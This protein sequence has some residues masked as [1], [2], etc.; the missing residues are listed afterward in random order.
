MQT[1]IVI[2]RGVTMG[3]VEHALE[4]RL[5]A[6]ATEAMLGGGYPHLY[7]AGVRYQRETP[8]SE[9]W[10]TPD[11]TIERGAGDCEDLAAYRC[12]ELRATG[13]DPEAVVRVVPAGRSTLHALI[14]RTTGPEEWEDPSVVLGMRPAGR[15][16]GGIY[17]PQLVAGLGAEDA[18]AATC[19]RVPSREVVVAPT[20]RQAVAELGATGIPVLDTI[21][22]AASGALRAVLPDGTV[23]RATAEQV[24][25]QTPGRVVQPGT[26]SPVAATEIVEL[27]ARIAQLVRREMQRTQKTGRSTMAGW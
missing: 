10:Q 8:G 17:M 22:R 18:W 1:Q 13:E 2:P 25:A 15:V 5:V 9:H 14:H 16:V 26:A 11:E 19:R 20:V 27:A 12:A 23:D 7:T 6:P 21:A 24:A 3:A 4:E